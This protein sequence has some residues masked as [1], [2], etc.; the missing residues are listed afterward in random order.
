MKKCCKFRPT[1]FSCFLNN[2][3][4]WNSLTYLS[5]NQSL[6]Q[7]LNLILSQMKQVY[8]L[9]TYFFNLYLILFPSLGLLRGCFLSNFLT[10]ILCEFCYLCHACYTLR[11]FH[12]PCF[13]YPNNISYRIRI[14]KSVFTNFPH[15]SLS[16]VPI[17]P[18]ISPRTIFSNLC[19]FSCL[20]LHVCEV[21]YSLML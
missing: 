16:F 3:T 15:C 4:P 6:D 13:N 19:L 5:R 9:I 7:P 20:G 11:L 21:P 1:T 17:I 18:N 2:L 12:L 14:I 8:I 10:K